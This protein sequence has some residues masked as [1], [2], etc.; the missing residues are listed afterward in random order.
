MP[1]SPAD[2]RPGPRTVLV[3]EPDAEGHSL[4]WLEHLIVFAGE[5]PDTSLVIV[6][7]EPLAQPLWRA[8][9]ADAAGR[10]QILALS[11]RE[12][13]MCTM[14][15]LALA[16]LA[17]WWTMRRYLK[18]SGADHGFFLGL[19]F[20]SLPL[21]LGLGGGGKG[22]SGILFRPSVHYGDIG[23]YVP[24]R[25]ERLRDRRKAILYRAML[26]NP[27]LERVLSLDPFFPEHA[28]ARYRGGEKVLALPDPAHPRIDQAANDVQPAF[29]IDRVGFLLFGYLAE[30]KGPL[31]VLD[32]LRELPPQVAARVAVLFAGKVDPELRAQLDRRR[33]ALAHERPELWLRID[34]RR[35]DSG[36]LAAVVRQSDVVL[37][38]YQRFVGSSGVL[39]WAALNGRPVLAQ[40]YGLVGRL[41]R[42]HRL[43]VSVDSCAPSEI[44][45]EIGRMVAEGPARSFDPKSA[46]RFAAAQ[47]PERF[48]S[49]VLSV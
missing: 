8:I 6:V 29:P 30:R 15:P 37:A 31:V 47:T 12:R 13:R 9:P 18:R 17:R 7:A 28:R 2:N 36:E 22:L 38:P 49:L 11:P 45:R 16:A 44:A 41:T 1:W 33:D 10:I 39:L 43:G 35:L 20:L 40:E 5:R 23:P 48:A 14:R 32:A 27:A 3:F 34:D 46:Q 24:S 19:D 42:E 25:G 4:E 21:A 26:R